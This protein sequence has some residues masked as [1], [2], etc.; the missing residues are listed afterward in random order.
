MAEVVAL[1]GHL[2]EDNRQRA[3]ESKNKRRALHLEAANAKRVK[4]GADPL[5]MQDGGTSN[6]PQRG[7]AAQLAAVNASMFQM[8]E[9]QAQGKEKSDKKRDDENKEFMA[10]MVQNMTNGLGQIF[11]AI[12]APAAA[13]A[14][15]AKGCQGKSKK[16]GECASE[17]FTFV[18]QGLTDRTNP[19]Y[20]NCAYCTHHRA[21]HV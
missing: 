6:V 18:E 12:A 7:T 1:T 21:R 14:A 13:P 17:C 16:D 20:H 5:T 8:M 19:E 4:G 3:L 11:H 10:A 9:V 2:S 15:P